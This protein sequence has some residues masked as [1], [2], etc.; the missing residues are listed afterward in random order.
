MFLPHVHVPLYNWKFAFSQ[1]KDLQSPTTFLLF[2]IDVYS[3]PNV[4]VLEIASS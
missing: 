1:L 2:M 4:E 3:F